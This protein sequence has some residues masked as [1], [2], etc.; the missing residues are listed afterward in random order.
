M[1]GIIYAKN[2]TGNEPVNNIIKVLYQNQKDRGQLGFGFVGMSSKSID[3]YRAVN[4]KEIMRYLNEKGYREIL[5]HHRNPT[6]TRN[7][8]KSTHPFIIHLNRKS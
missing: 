5:F 8:I 3:T 6:S 4:E 7:T 1:C 2:L